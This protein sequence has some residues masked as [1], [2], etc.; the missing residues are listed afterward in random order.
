VKRQYRPFFFLFLF[1]LFSLPIIAQ[2]PSGLVPFDVLASKIES[3]HHVKLY[4]KASW[5]NEKL[6]KETLADMP[7]EECL[8]I[9]K[10]GMNLDC[11]KMKPDNYVFVPVEVQ[12]YTNHTNNNGVLLIGDRNR[13]EKG[14]KATLSG[15][16]SDVYTGRPLKDALVSIEELKIA[17]TT[18]KDGNYTFQVPVGEYV[19]TLHHVGFGEDIRKISVSGNGVVDFEMSKKTIRLKEVVISDRVPDQ[20]IVSTQMSTIKLNAKAIKEL[21]LFLGEKDI[22]K[23]IKLLPGVQSTGEFGT[24]FFVRGGSQ[25]QNLILIED[26]PI[27]NSA[28]AFGLI[29]ALNSDGI[30]S[31]TLLK[32]GIPAKYGERASSVMDIRMGTNPEKT[33]FKGGI[34][35]M[36]SRLNFET[37]LFNKKVGLL[38]GARTSYSNWLLHK[39]PDADLRNSSVNF[40]DVNA[41]LNI[42]LDPKNK[43]VLYGYYS[44]DKYSLSNE[45]QY[46]YDNTLGSI[47]YMHQF[48]EK[49]NSTLMAGMSRYRNDMSESDT[50]EPTEAYKIH[51]SI[52]YY[53][54]KLAFNWLPTD[55][56]SIDFGLNVLLYQ[57]QPGIREPLGTL[58]EVDYETT[59]KEKAIEMAFYVSDKILLS[60]NLSVDL[61]LRFTQYAYLGPNSVFSFSEN[62]AHTSANITDTLNY[63]NNEIIKWYSSL[64]PRLSIRYSLDEVSS[65]KLSYNRISQFINLISNTTVMT[66]T[67]VYKLS[68]PNVKPVVCDQIAFGYFRN[69]K[70]NTMEASVEIY[71]KKLKNILEYRDGAEILL[72]NSLEADL[73]NAS[74]YNYGI[75]FSLRKNAGPL[76]GW[77][78]YTYSR[79]LRHTTSP[80]ESDQINGNNYFPSASDQ[81]HNIVLVGNYHLTRRWMLSGTFNYSTGRPVTLPE[82]KYTFDGKQYVYYSERNKYRLPDYHRLDIAITHDETLRLK[83]PWKG[84]WTFSILNL[85]AR[86]NPYS[87]FYKASSDLESKF[88]ST[89]YLYK[90]YII[91]KPIPTITY[92]FTF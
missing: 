58:S 39:M 9:I 38:I 79:S 43:L 75:E 83:Q 8:T 21:P 44:D 73:L 59:Q 77:A 47:Q 40:F 62:A 15:R 86:K 50:L 57:I 35:L 52:H 33:A 22:L 92:N 76:T 1:L 6:F 7:L 81:P 72:N 32:S 13:L 91:E 51:S 41:L 30:N 88:H 20:N 12:N 68:S 18:D 10:R 3:V 61:G 19:L 71:Y 42:K 48:N 23:G 65:L 54:T 60:S 26:V 89:I 4:Y 25:D 55:I 64:E 45:Y 69:F 53:S 66:P 67:D 80:Y 56:H 84:S 28:H 90:M 24:G 34:G 63:G 11:I 14:A 36:D 31:V 16:I 78:S 87:V 5:F 2:H 37:P 85:Y 82:L 49:L 46:H 74:G 27:F 17:A 70:Q 29:S